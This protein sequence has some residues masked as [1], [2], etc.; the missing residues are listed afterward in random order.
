MAANSVTS[1]IEPYQNESQLISLCPPVPTF[2]GYFLAILVK[3]I[4][5]VL[6]FTNISVTFQASQTA[7]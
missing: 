3:L 7:R 5:N 6:Q 4:S 2:I 1:N